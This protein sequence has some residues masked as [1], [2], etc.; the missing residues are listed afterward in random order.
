MMTTIFDTIH[1]LL[2]LPRQLTATGGHLF[3][4]LAFLSAAILCAIYAYL[5][6]RRVYAQRRVLQFF[7][8]GQALLL[9][10]LALDHQFG[11]LNHLTAAGRVR[12]L[13]DGWYY[14]RHAVQF[15]LIIGIGAAG[16]LLFALTGWYFRPI[17]RHHWL[18][19]LS[20]AGLLSY[21]GIRA[22]SLH[23]VDALLARRVAGLPSGWL[24][25]L[26]GLFFLLCTLALSF[27]WSRQ[28]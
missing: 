16:L 13:E 9:L 14:G 18:P 21:V 27:E 28:P 6:N 26:G 7:Y 3:M 5:L 15:D 12:A 8:G 19:L 20:A 11:L 10:G 22:V 23:G 25:E 2:R 1:L 4:G 17:L 24:L